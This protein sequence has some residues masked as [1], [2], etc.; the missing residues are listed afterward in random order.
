VSD[1][2]PSGRIPSGWYLDPDPNAPA[3][4]QRYWDGSAWTQR[5][6]APTTASTVA[7]QARRP[8]SFTRWGIPVLVGVVA[9]LFGIG[10]GA[11]PDADTSPTA[12][13]EP[14]ATATV[15]ATVPAA[16]PQ[17][18]LDALATWTAKAAVETARNTPDGCGSSGRTSMASTTTA[19]ESAASRHD[20]ERDRRAWVSS[21]ASDA[22]SHS[23]NHRATGESSGLIDLSATHT[24]VKCALGLV[25]ARG[26]LIT[27]NCPIVTKQH[28]CEAPEH[29]TT[30]MRAA[31]S[32]VILPRQRLQEGIRLPS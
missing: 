30:S 12:S 14:M 10:V 3:G 19:M 24:L 22:A 7:G 20:G 28:A 26:C 15:T 5:T 29:S 8:G 6:T 9:F 1:Q 16:V 13:S 11:D 17:D 18:Q 32:L 27:M 21:C 31:A 4:Q 23:A 25:V 2:I